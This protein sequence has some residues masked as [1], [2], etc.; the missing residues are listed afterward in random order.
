MW[1]SSST[2]SIPQRA[3]TYRYMREAD[4]LSKC[5]KGGIRTKRLHDKCEFSANKGTTATRSYNGFHSLY[6]SMKRECSK[7]K[8]SCSWRLQCEYHKE[9]TAQCVQQHHESA[10][11]WWA[12]ADI[13]QA[14][15]D[16]NGR[17]ARIGDMSRAVLMSVLDR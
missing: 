13:Y 15:L 6:T 8:L 4:A 14:T 9:Q 2:T 16:N 17:T 3:V 10:S 7:Q 12:M 1:S 11:L 5:N